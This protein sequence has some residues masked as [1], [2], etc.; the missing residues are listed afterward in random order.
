MIAPASFHCMPA[1]PRSCTC[2]AGDAELLW[3]SVACPVSVTTPRSETVHYR[4]EDANAEAGKCAAPVAE[5]DGNHRWMLS[6]EVAAEYCDGKIVSE[7]WNH[8]ICGGCGATVRMATRLAMSSRDA[9]R[10]IRFLNRQME[11]IYEMRCAIAGAPSVVVARDF[12]TFLPFDDSGAEDAVRHFICEGEWRALSAPALNGVYHRG[13]NALDLLFAIH[14]G[15]RLALRTGTP[16]ADDQTA[17]ITWLFVDNWH[18]SKSDYLAEM[19][20]NHADE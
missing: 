10:W 8:C 12:A 5:S 6:F 3:H 17:V 15:N 14:L 11:T 9:G 2:E 18:S 20:P 7:G 1:A 13:K 16:N 19:L 4:I